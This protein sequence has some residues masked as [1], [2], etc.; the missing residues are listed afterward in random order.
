MRADYDRLAGILRS[1]REIPYSRFSARAIRQ[2]RE[3]DREIER[4]DREKEKKKDSPENDLGRSQDNF[5]RA[6]WKSAPACK[7]T[8]IGITVELKVFICKI[9]D[10]YFDSFEILWVHTVKNMYNESLHE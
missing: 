8:R 2:K 9:D 4:R 10:F 7:I 1:P 3:I 5:V 6:S